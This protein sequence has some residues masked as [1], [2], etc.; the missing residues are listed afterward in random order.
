MREM[1]GFWLV[2]MTI[3]SVLT[4]A[5]AFYDFKAWIGAIA[6]VGTALAM[7]LI[8]LYLMMGG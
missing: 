2:A 6:M 4:V 7:L 3:A 5:D 8:G 1:I